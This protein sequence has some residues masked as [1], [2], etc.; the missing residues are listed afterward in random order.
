MLL[1]SAPLRALT[2]QAGL[3]QQLLELK[4]IDEVPDF[5]TQSICWETK[6]K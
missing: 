3:A 2:Q 4:K 1:A 6:M 5:L